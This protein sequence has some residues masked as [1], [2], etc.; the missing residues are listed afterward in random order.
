MTLGEWLAGARLRVPALEAQVLAGHVLGWD[1]TRVLAHPEVEVPEF[2][3]EAALQRLEAGE[4]L[5]YITGR[6]EFFG[7]D[8][9]VSPA[10]LIPRQETE[11]LVEA[12]LEFAAVYP[13]L[14]RVL[15]IG[16]GSGCI[17]VSLKKSRPTLQVFAVDLS[18]EA[19]EIA[20]RNA[21]THG[22]EIEFCLGD[23][24]EL[25]GRGFDILVSNPPYI[26]ESEVTG[27]GVREFE[28]HLALF[29]GPTGL[30]FYDR[31]SD[32]LTSEH[33]FVEVG[34][35]QADEV[36]ALFV[37]KGHRVVARHRDLL[38]IDRVI[39]VGGRDAKDLSI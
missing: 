36:A 17:A 4:P 28:P 12:A 27:P 31:L 1:R 37:A 24:V 6:R 22:A 13:G 20:R 7:L 26:G 9:A 14:G 29:A 8:F 11:V 16:T 21:A 34:D 10:V 19:L 15:D 35:R 3:L 23:G 39:H 18:A 5:A 25:I 2:A 30:E 33:L 38:G 32:A